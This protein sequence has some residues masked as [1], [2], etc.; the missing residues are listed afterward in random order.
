MR[1]SIQENPISVV[2]IIR[3]RSGL[4]L[5]ELIVVM[6][7]LTTLITIAFSIYN[8]FINKAKI[9]VAQSVLTNVQKNI[10]VYNMDKGSYPASIDFTNC[11]D[12]QGRTVL[13][14]TL[15]DQLKKDLFSNNYTVNG[16]SYELKAQAKDAKNTLLTLTPNNITIQGN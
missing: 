1:K 9:T 16:T 15:C 14:P 6:I 8:N 7:I 13:D 11:I 10:E 2:R 5:I 12:D 4:T 3:G